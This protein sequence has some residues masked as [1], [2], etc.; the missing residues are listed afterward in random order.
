MCPATKMELSQ[1]EANNNDSV[2]T[3]AIPKTPYRVKQ[4]WDPEVFFHATIDPV[5]K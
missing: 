2:Y 5:M 1:F 3:S 4:N